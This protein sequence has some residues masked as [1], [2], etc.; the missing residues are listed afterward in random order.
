MCFQWL[1]KI[2]LATVL[3]AS[4]SAQAGVITD[5]K[6]VNTTISAFGSFDWTHDINSY[7]FTPGSALS[8]T[9]SI[10][11]KDKDF[12][13]QLTSIVVGTIDFLDGAIVYNPNSEFNDSLGFKS[14]ASLNSS[15]KVDVLV[16]SLFLGEFYIGDSTL[17]VFTSD[18]ASVPESSSLALLALGLLGLVV[19]RRKNAV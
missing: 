12:W 9:L 16:Q 13:P 10:E 15:G 6:D 4:F 7:G 18:T 14:L 3:L 19:L 1:K 2:A 17:T 5:V 8:A 11:F